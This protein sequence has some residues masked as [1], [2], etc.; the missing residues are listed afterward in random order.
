MELTDVVGDVAG[1]LTTLS[2]LPQV[3]K[4]WRT[5]S[6]ADISLTMFLM[7][8]AGVALW[9]VYGVLLDSVPLIVSNIVTLFLA[10]IILALKLRSVWQERR[11]RSVPQHEDEVV[12]AQQAVAGRP[13][14][15]RNESERP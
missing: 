7:F 3:I 14:F 15:R 1:T 8:C 12:T 11:G 10:G 2:F 5:R 9:L 4:T 13:A 6:T